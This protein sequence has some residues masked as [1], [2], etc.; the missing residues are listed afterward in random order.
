[1]P[2]KTIIVA[3]LAVVAAVLP[4]PLRAD[5]AETHSQAAILAE[6]GAKVEA[7]MLARI[8]VNEADWSEADC[9]AIWSVVLNVRSR[10]C[11]PTRAR[12]GE[13]PV[14]E[15]EAEDGSRFAPARSPAAG[16]QETL[17]SAMRRLSRSTTGHSGP[18]SA[19]QRW[20][21]TL[22]D[23]SA[24]PPGWRECGQLPPE[25]GCDGTWRA[26]A[27]AWGRVRS[28]ARSLV[29]SGRHSPQCGAEGQ[30]RVIAWGGEMDRW[31]AERRGLV[32]VD[33]GDTA[34][35]FYAL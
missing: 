15:C 7:L 18:R 4:G 27:G 21:A 25:T 20:T 19:R 35:R 22:Q 14:T 13:V 11:D 1:M 28:L 29:A 5:G 16:A 10:R 31:L 9:R 32:E 12:P 6:P 24:P 34:N 33:C 26:H 8:C 2:R 30:R 23:S 3:C 17:L